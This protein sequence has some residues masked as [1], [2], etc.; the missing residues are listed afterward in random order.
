MR[1]KPKSNLTILLITGIL[2]LVL[3]QISIRFQQKNHTDS[4]L[5]SA[6]SAGNIIRI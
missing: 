6:I 1:T 3:I 4:L 2:M 5:K